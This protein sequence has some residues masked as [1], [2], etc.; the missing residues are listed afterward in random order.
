MG[1]G[2]VT[3]CGGCGS[4]CAFEAYVDSEGFVRAHMPVEGHPCRAERLCG[5]GKRR[6]SLSRVQ[7]DRVE[8][9]LRRCEDGT[10]EAISWEQAYAEIAERLQTVIEQHGPSSLACTMG[11]TQHAGFY[12]RRL[13]A[14]LGSPNIYGAAGACEVS[15]VTGWEHTLG[16]SPASDV[17][18]TNYIVYLGR[19]PLDSASVDES[20]QVEKALRR[21]ASVVCV[22]PRRNSTV[23]YATKWLKIR[24]G[25]DLALLLGIAH[26]LIEE[27]LYDAAFVERYTTGFEEFARAMEPYTAAWAASE[28]DVPEEDILA[29]ARGLGEAR[30]RAVVDCGFHG[31]IGVAYVNCTQ[32]ARMIALVN[33]LLGNYGQEGGNLNPAQSI[34]LGE[35]DP[36]RFP[37]P[38]Q[39]SR[40]KVGADRYPLVDPEEGLCTTIGES[41][42]LGEIHALFAYASNP[43]MGYGNARDWGR[44]LG[45][46]DLLVAIDIR[47][48]ETAL[49]ADYVLPDVTF[50]ES[51]RGV[52]SRGSLL[53]Y[54]NQVL[55]PKYPDARPT[56]RIVRGLADRLGLGRYFAF[57]DEELA[58]ARVAPY[59]VDL[60]E[61]R[62][63]GYA[64]TGIDISRRVGEPV[65]STPSGTIDF[66]SDVWEAAGLGRT[67]FW[68]PPLVDPDAEGF[69]LINGNSPFESHT[70]TCMLTPRPGD[71]AHESMA[72]VWLH[73]DRAR[74]LGIADGD[75]IE[76]YS[77][78]GCDRA[79]AH[80]TRDLHPDAL[81]T[82][83]SPGGRSGR[84]AY[85]SQAP[86]GALGV[87]PLDHTPLRYDALTG[88]ALTQENVVHIRKTK[89]L[90][91]GGE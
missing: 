49:L 23:D 22:D 10:F 62:R 6:L 71:P 29:V 66:A 85:H 19:S 64:D 33:A 21:G 61:L 47:M 12:V 35:L 41:I 54:R 60:E 84:N 78:L 57:S 48:S 83:A 52:G 76:V 65:I 2:I 79:V 46:L 16:Y 51:D 81:Y 44:L 31:G 69:R 36:L 86:L 15:R 25:R 17:E 75:V 7:R 59:G 28:C 20:A 68:Q 3:V 32:N 80:V 18:H 88:S 63:V 87:G 74:R 90:E 45:E 70:S 9:P 30:P 50:L 53:Y 56:S 39:P 26:V 27:G 34:P 67:P 14:A 40:P 89:G 37:T 8:H 4:E 38:A 24:P 82:S 55:P 42:E 1:D 58:Q 11:I 72:S 5:R 91:P 77:E 13:M 43:A 73:A